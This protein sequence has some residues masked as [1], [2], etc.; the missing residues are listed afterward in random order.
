MEIVLGIDIGGTTTTLGF[1]DKEGNMLAETVIP[2]Q[3]GQHITMYLPRLFSAIDALLAPL[4]DTHTWV[5]IGIGAP[6]GNY[7][8]GTVEN[9]PN[10]QWGG[11]IPLCNLFEEKYNLPAFLTNDANAAA[12][13]EMK[14]GVA[15]GMKDFI[16]LTLGTG[17]GSG[18]V[19]NG[20]LVYGHTGFAGELGHSTV[21]YDGRLC[22]CGKRGCLETYVSVTGIR[23][24]VSKLLADT[25]VHSELRAV[26]QQDLTG[27]MIT[28][29]AR[30][31][32]KIAL[33][34]FEYT[35]QIFGRK[36]TEFTVFTSPEA[37]ILFG[38][39]ARAENLL[40][41]PTLKHMEANMFGAFHGTVKLM[42]SSLQ[43]TNA[44]VLGASALAW[45]EL[46][47]Q[48]RKM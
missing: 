11:V 14:F 1:T 5:G 31:G 7:F 29:A 3:A 47:K 41:Q 36:L 45:H 34:A 12:I 2:T 28:N 8:K 21:N 17:L 44:A 43:D 27:E 25:L 32:D 35:G 16:L 26:S 42:Y 24:T 9:P 48:K 6:N 46:E 39:L 33:E 37:F 13:G 30:Q 22:G 15:K 40:L 38:G 23:R 20:E 18:I 19:V 4:K 10:L